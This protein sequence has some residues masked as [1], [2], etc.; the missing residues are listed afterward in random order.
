MAKIDIVKAEITV[1]QILMVL[2][3]GINAG[4]ISWMLK[5]DESTKLLLAVLAVAVLSALLVLL[6]KTIFKKIKTLGDL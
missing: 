3:F 4:L 1:Y 5:N 6:L 2:V